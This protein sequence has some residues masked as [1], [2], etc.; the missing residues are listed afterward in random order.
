MKI[1]GADFSLNTSLTL[2]ALL[3]EQGYNPDHV[4]VEINGA[5]I[6][7]TAYEETF[8]SDDDVIEVVRFVGGG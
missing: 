5:V 8:L 6:P 2:K 4:A 7:K 3:L 1:N